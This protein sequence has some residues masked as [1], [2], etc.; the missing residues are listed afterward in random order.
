[1]KISLNWISDYVNLDGINPKELA[2]KLTMSTAE[3]EE[4]IEMGKDVKDVVVGKI[5][6]VE[7]HPSSQK[8][9]IVRVDTGSETVQSV[10]GA[11]NVEEGALV[12]FAKLGGQI[13]KVPE[14]KKTMLSGV[15]SN[16]ILCSGAEIGVN[17]SSDQLLILDDY[18]QPGKDLKEIYGIDDTVIEIDNKSLTHR[19][20]LWGHY[21]IAREIAAILKRPLLPVPQ[22]QLTHS[23][24]LPDLNIQIDEPEKCFRYSCITVENVVENQTPLDMQ[25]RLYY[26]GQNPI[27]LLV[28]LSNYV[29]MDI[30]QPNHAFDH[31][32][33]SNIVVKFPPKPL[34]GFRTLDCTPRDIPEDVLMIYNEDTP[35]ALAGIMGGE[36]SEITDSTT[37]LF[38]E[39]ANFDGYTVRK[40]ASAL[41]MRTDASARFEKSLDPALTTTAIKRFIY[42]LKL[43]QPE[44]K[45]TSNL[46]DLYVKEPAP[47]TIQFDKPYLDRLIGKDLT[48]ENIIDILERLEFK[49]EHEEEHKDGQFKVKVPQFRATRDISIKADMVE[50][51][52]RIYGYDNIEPQTVEVPLE[53]LNYNEDRLMEHK[54]KEVLTE[55][56][57]ID[58]AHSYTWYDNEFNKRL[59]IQHEGFI[60]LVNPHDQKMD[61]MR[62]SMVPTMLQFAERNVNQYST[63][64]LFEIG[65]VY[66]LDKKSGEKSDA[67]SDECDEHKNLCI[68]LAD[69]EASEDALFYSLKGVA[70]YLLELLRGKEFQ[71]KPLP[72]SLTYPWLHPE[73]SAAVYLDDRLTGYLS[74]L[75]PNVRQHI[76]KKARIALLEI[77]F[78][79]VFNSEEQPVRFKEISKFPE[80]T[81]DFSFLAG[82]ATPFEEVD[83]HVASFKSELLQSYK[84]VT[85]YEGKSLPQGKKSL[86]F[87]FTLGSK[88]KT[89]V[90]DD[91]NQ[92]L[93]Q[94]IKHMEIKGYVLRQG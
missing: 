10:C 38:L 39:S 16:G 4:V 3:V 55:K 88:E 70:T 83:R 42:L 49:V 86:T 63:I 1:M 31:R 72:K 62:V 58:E 87:A 24:K 23:K 77:D 71:Y 28:D 66:F 20:D 56:F 89:L 92:F 44:I 17:N 43:S 75:H 7:P 85:I 48:T 74:V 19:P 36:E 12:P 25:M 35:V 94:L 47:I 34:K 65:K 14:I 51:I 6:K 45:I 22:T 78:R 30:G 18:L 91:I 61:T 82:T 64:P 37:S 13:L 79:H 26:C 27:S 21:G 5:V 57:G 52:T 59:Q 80:V 33:A 60:K 32:F 90:N 9:K 68:M 76:D 40:G 93:N 46:S 11:P 67:K 69:K 73:K 8:L 50:E 29:M 81:L 84:Y 53:P 15:E 54:I 41:N 2:L